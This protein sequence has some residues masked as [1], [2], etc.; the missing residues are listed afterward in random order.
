M[1][2]KS[3]AVDQRAKGREIWDSW[4]LVTHI[5]CTFHLVVVK[6]ILGPFNVFVSKCHVPGKQ[7]V[8][9]QHDVTLVTNVWGTLCYAVF[10]VI[11]GLR[12]AFFS[13]WPEV[14]NTSNTNM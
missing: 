3:K 12:G 4:A 5:W 11:W 6:V 2:C 9:E 14:R 7:A 8:A 1:S 13:K 10:D